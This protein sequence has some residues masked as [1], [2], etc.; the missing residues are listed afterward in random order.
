[1]GS[2]EVEDPLHGQNASRCLAGRKRVR[3]NIAID[4]CD[5]VWRGL[6]IFFSMSEPTCE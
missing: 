5:R 3:R 1:M 6:R 4:G 2:A